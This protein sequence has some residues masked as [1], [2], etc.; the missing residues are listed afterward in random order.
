MA[1][2]FRRAGRGGQRRYVA[3]LDAGERELVATL[4][5]QVADLLAPPDPAGAT[6]ATGQ[7]PTEPG[8]GRL[9]DGFDA[10]V[11]GMGL[12]R[13]PGDAGADAPTG[14]AATDDAPARDPALDRLLPSG[15]REDDGAATEFRRLTEGGLRHRKAAAL[16]ASVAVLREAGDTVGLDEGQA[17]AFVTALTDVRLVLGERL[18]LRTDE[19][20]DRLEELVERLDDDE[21]VVYL[22]ALYDFLT[23]L[24]ET[25]ASALMRR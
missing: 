14:D 3:T 11:A 4:M 21:P 17:V 9:D 1:R 5:G 6:G 18:G 25:L 24:Q 23:W 19:D 15:H 20:L 12:A 8:A 7:S 16:T 13:A 10:I 22:L 2:G